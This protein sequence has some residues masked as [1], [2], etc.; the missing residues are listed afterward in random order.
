MQNIL[1]FSL[2]AS[3]PGTPSWHRKAL[4]DL[5]SMVDA[6]GFPNIFITF[7]ADEVSSTKWP[8]IYTIEALAKALNPQFTW[9][10][11]PVECALLFHSRLHHF[12]ESVHTSRKTDSWSCS[13]SPCALWD[14]KQRLC[15]CTCYF[16][17]LWRR[18][19]TNNNA[20]GRQPAMFSSVTC[21]CVAKMVCFGCS[22]VRAFMFALNRSNS[23][24]IKVSI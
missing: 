12:Y 22:T 6:W 5:I 24:Y 17:D 7:T 2:P 14:S 11:C 1:R 21:F 13:T 10:Y 19:R 8:E 23:R 4:K 9:R 20:L 15:A 18:H 16:M 3:I